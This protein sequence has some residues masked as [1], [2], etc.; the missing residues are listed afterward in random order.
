MLQNLVNETVSVNPFD[1]QMGWNPIT[2]FRIVV[3]RLVYIVQNITLADCII[4]LGV[5]L[6]AICIT[7]I[8]MIIQFKIKESNGLWLPKSFRDDMEEDGGCLVI[9]N[10]ETH[11]VEFVDGSLTFYLRERFRSAQLTKKASR[12]L[13]MKYCFYVDKKYGHHPDNVR[14]NIAYD[15][16]RLV[17]GK[18]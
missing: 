18:I 16:E 11:D 17:N 15:A 8:V 2:N 10:P 13:L 6:L 14:M 4:C 12:E 5:S 7:L 9:T 3:L 1:I